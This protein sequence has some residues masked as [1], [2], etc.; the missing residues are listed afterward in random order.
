DCFPLPAQFRCDE[1][2]WFMGMML[3]QDH[4]VLIL[5]PSWVLGESAPTGPAS[6]GQTEQMIAATPLPVGRLVC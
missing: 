3:Y 6:T 1:Q 4:L 5:N 2:N